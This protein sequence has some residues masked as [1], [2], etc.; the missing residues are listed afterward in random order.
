MNRSDPNGFEGVAA[1]LI[2][3]ALEL[4]NNNVKVGVIYFGSHV[5]SAYEELVDSSKIR[6]KLQ[7]KNF[8][9]PE[10]FT[11][12][13][14]GL[15]QALTLIQS[16]T[17]IEKKIVLI[18]DGVPDMPDGSG[19]QQRQVILTKFVAQAKAM[20]IKVYAL[21]LSNQ[22][23]EDFLRQITEP[24]EGT[25]SA[26]DNA[27]DMLKSANKLLFGMD[28]LVQVKEQDLPASQDSFMFKMPAGLERGKITLVFDDYAVFFQ[29]EIAINIQGPS[30]EFSIEDGQAFYSDNS[31]DGIGNTV[32]AW[33]LFIDNPPA[34]DYT[35]KLASQKPGM[36]DHG[37][38]KILVE[39]RTNLNLK[40]VLSPSPANGYQYG[41]EIGVTVLLSSP[42]GT[43]K[44]TSISGRVFAPGGGSD[45]IQFNPG[46]IKGKFKLLSVPGQQKILV[47]AK[48]GNIISISKS[49]TFRAHEP[50]PLELESS[51]AQLKFSQPLS[52]EVTEVEMDFELYL[53]RAG[54]AEKKRGDITAIWLE[55]PIF[56][57]QSNIVDW[58]KLQM[59]S[60]SE[61]S[62]DNKSKSV[63]FLKEGLPLSLIFAFPDVSSLQPLTQKSGVHKGVLHIET[64]LS[65]NVLDIP[66]EI[67]LKMPE[68]V[69]SPK[70]DRVLW[71]DNEHDRTIPL[72]NVSYDLSKDEVFN[73]ILPSKLQTSAQNTIAELLL[74]NDSKP[75]EGHHD[76]A[77][78]V[79]GPLKLSREEMKLS[80]ALKL[81]E[82]LNEVLLL[83]KNPI[84]YEII[85]LYGSESGTIGVWTMGPSWFSFSKLGQL[86][87]HVRHLLIYFLGLILVLVLIRTFN[88]MKK[89][90]RES[91][92][93]RG[94]RL[95]CTTKK[96]SFNVGKESQ[97]LNLPNSIKL[98]NE[99]PGVYEIEENG[100][101]K[102]KGGQLL[103]N[104]SQ[105]ESNEVETLYSGD[106]IGLSSGK[107]PQKA[108]WEL[109]L[110]SVNEDRGEA[111]FRIGK[112]PFT[113]TVFNV[114]KGF[115]FLALFLFILGAV[116]NSDWLASLVY[117]IPG[118]DAF[119]YSIFAVI[120]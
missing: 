28:N 110:S 119:F 96:G 37:G 57:N 19:P 36:P 48:I 80:L 90:R 4:A 60:G 5:S 78:M 99:T 82:N 69:V 11:N 114:I 29:D 51:H 32:T 75:V 105:L 34:G 45:A 16:S 10:G 30:E 27:R 40:L 46:S 9:E 98:S 43:Q 62:L 64:P 33:S 120:S 87:L 104:G 79:Y 118:A 66:V 100:D 20:N 24:T 12:M 108:I 73:I 54:V 97:G 63:M 91:A 77:K 94:K 71:W 70:A 106:K 95:K 86:S 101:F 38:I 17:A 35:I 113:T 103:V 111:A 7:P 107:K 85:S 42:S 67:E 18:T 88:K 1:N 58:A 92:Y 25:F 72:V 93:H 21:G 13:Q 68:L 56:K 83:E 55:M 8:P 15:E 14:K 53:K 2:L 6:Q 89:V 115:V 39:G 59:K 3:D 31:A 74:L 50:D 81:T 117:K 44:P 47:T 22:V 112:T 23:D 109:K 84:Q 49:V 61:L 41:D 26:S 102:V 65:Q 116:V 52:P 76:G